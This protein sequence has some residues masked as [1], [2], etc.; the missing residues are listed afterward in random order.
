MT[1]QLTG[2]RRLD[3][4]DTRELERTQRRFLLARAQLAAGRDEPLR[5]DAARRTWRS[6]RR[7]F[8]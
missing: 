2:P 3:E 1:E 8:S 7:L 4:Q 6:H 5:L